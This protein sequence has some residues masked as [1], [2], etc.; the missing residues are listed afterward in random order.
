MF[1]GISKYLLLILLLL[2]QG[3]V[4]AHELDLDAHQANDTCEVCLLHSALDHSQVSATIC[5]WNPASHAQ[6]S[7][8]PS[9]PLTLDTYKLFRARAPPQSTTV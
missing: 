7:V 8:T 6:D 4:L 2:G 5:I 9:L 3:S 1:T